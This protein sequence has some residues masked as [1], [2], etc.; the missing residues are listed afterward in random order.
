MERLNDIAR[1]IGKDWVESP[2]Y[3]DAEKFIDTQWDGLIWP[4]IQGSDFSNTIDLAAGHG[5]NTKKLKKIAQKLWVV[6]MNKE[7]VEFCKL[8]FAKDDRIVFLLNDG[9]SL[10]GVQDESIT[11]IY[12]FDAMVHF[13]SDIIRN[14]L[15]E[16]QRVLV[17]GGRGFCHHSNYSSNPTGDF[18]ENPGWRNYMS[19]NLFAHYCMKEELAVIKQKVIDWEIPEMD[20]FSLFE[21]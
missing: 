5:R 16:F 13:D 2:Y 12:C 14:Y 6:D 21:K 9:V 1:D 17:P 18:R 8:R 4:F 7:N 19:D 10:S 15:K 3:E 20:C 11:F